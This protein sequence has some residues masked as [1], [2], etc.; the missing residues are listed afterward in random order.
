MNDQSNKKSRLR[1][2]K[3]YVLG[4]KV[5]VA[6]IAC[7]VI[8]ILGMS[9][10]APSAANDRESMERQLQEQMEQYETLQ[11]NFETLSVQ[12]DDMLSD[13]DTLKAELVKYQDQQK[14][15]DDLNSQLE[16]LQEKYDALSGE[17]EELRSQ[18][19]SLQTRSSSTSSSSSSSDAGLSNDN[20]GGT[21]WLSATG[22]KYHS[23]PG[24]GNMNPDNAR[25]VSKS[26]AE[27]QGYGAC[28]K[29]W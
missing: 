17:N 29:C 9:S 21:V 3:Q 2:I 14:T 27:A 6:I 13:Y 22:S 18:V 20:S 1:K 5:L 12:Y 24:C 26:S 10:T 15:I 16:V 4:N 25:Q 8:C 23:V 7:L 11:S 19:S 28:S